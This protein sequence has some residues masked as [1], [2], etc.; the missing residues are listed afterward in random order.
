MIRKAFVGSILTLAAVSTAAATDFHVNKGV[1]CSDSNPG[2]S[3][4]P[5]CSVQAGLNK[6]SAAGD[7]VIIHT[8]V[9][10]E[11]AALARSVRGTATSPIRIKGADG[12]S[13][14]GI[15]IDAS[16]LSA[17]QCPVAALS[18][19]SAS[20]RGALTLK[21]SW[22]SQVGYVEVSNL[23]VRP[24]NLARVD[25]HAA[26]FELLARAAAEFVVAE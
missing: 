1:A 21:G 25:T 11:C 26:R 8:G 13:P 14:A 17:A 23:T 22:G 2:T 12:E 5:L 16:T 20:R 7:A 24:V 9:Y 19:D 10:N 18:C 4:Q 6:L 3:A 15:I